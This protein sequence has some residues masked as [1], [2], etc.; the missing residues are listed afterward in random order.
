[1][2]AGHTSLGDSPRRYWA[3]RASYWY[4]LADCCLADSLGDSLDDSRTHQL[5]WQPG[6]QQDTPAWLTAS[7]LLDTCLINITGT[8]YAFPLYSHSF[9]TRIVPNGFVEHSM[10]YIYVQLPILRTFLP[11]SLRQSCS[12]AVNQQ[13]VYQGNTARE[14]VRETVRETARET[15]M[16]YLKN[17]KE[18]CLVVLY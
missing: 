5:G 16:L 11:P 10:L 9:C 14:T 12:K 8:Q 1:M 3:P 13:K 17:R 18:I 4:M 2:T 7:T 15:A 6:W